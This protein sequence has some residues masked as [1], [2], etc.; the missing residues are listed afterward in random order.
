MIR[1]FGD[2]RKSAFPCSNATNSLNQF[3]Q[4]TP[5]RIPTIQTP[6]ALETRH[7]VRTFRPVQS[8][9]GVAP[10]QELGSSNTRPHPAF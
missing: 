8:V 6:H 5:K 2:T 7:A 10:K 4:T 9:V 1:V 3:E